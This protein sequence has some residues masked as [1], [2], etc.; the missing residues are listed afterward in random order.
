MTREEW[1]RHAVEE[2]YKTH[3]R[4]NMLHQIKQDRRAE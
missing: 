4:K 3:R 1:L 2:L